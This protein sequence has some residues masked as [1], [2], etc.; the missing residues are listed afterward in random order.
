MASSGISGN[1][2]NKMQATYT[3]AA[4]DVALPATSVA[5]AAAATRIDL[6]LVVTREQGAP[7]S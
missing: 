5:A 1:Q 4:T 6:Q 3:A 7:L 2:R